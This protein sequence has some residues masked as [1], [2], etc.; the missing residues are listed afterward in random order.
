MA[1]GVNRAALVSAFASFPGH[2]AKASRDA[3]PDAIA[4]GEWGPTEVVRHLVAVESQVWQSRLAEV[5]AE[6]D[7]YWPWTEPG[8]ADGFAGESLETVLAV[9]E[10][11]RATTEAT[12]LA[13]DDAGWI[14]SGTHATYGVL[15]VE[16][17]LRIAMDHDASHL[18]GL[19][20]TR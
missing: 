7:P 5:A 2:L 13:L 4:P 10:A 14:R 9:F 15:D 8:L 12:L 17:L 18:E 19:R 1:A 20:E 11:A 16:G 6:S 3:A